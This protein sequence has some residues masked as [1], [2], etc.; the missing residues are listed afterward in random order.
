[1]CVTSTR[2]AAHRLAGVAQH[3]GV[4]GRRGAD[5]GRRIV[6][7]PGALVPE[8][9]AAATA[10]IT[11]RKLRYWDEV[12]LISPSVRRRL[13]RKVVR[14]Y[15]LDEVLQL[16][17]AG[18]LRDSLSLQQIRKIVRQQGVTYDSPLSELCFAEHNGEIYFQHPDGTW[19]AN[20]PRGKV[21]SPGQYPSNAS[22]E[23]S[24]T[25]PTGQPGFMGGLRS[26]EGRSGRSP[27]SPAREYQ[28]PRCRSTYGVGT[29][30]LTS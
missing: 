11:R 4:N 13:G 9:Q 3:S 12:G 17:V 2:R 6:E 16:S 30:P 14:L 19:E 26:A 1:M 18:W 24:T 25:P 10:K 22:G 27:F 8:K 29:T 15:T 7:S 23:A 21:S 20:K 5:K 28:F